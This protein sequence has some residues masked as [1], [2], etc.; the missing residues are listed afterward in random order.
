MSQIQE[1]NANLRKE[2][3]TLEYE[4][5]QL[6]H[7][8][9][10]LEEDI[11]HA[12]GALQEA[13]DEVNDLDKE[14]EQVKAELAAMTK[15]CGLLQKSSEALKTSSDE[16]LAA[17]RKRA[18]E[19]NNEKKILEEELERKGKLLRSQEDNIDEMEDTIETLR[20]A[21]QL[22]RGTN[23]QNEKNLMEA[24]E[25]NAKLAKE[26][27]ELKEKVLSVE[28][29]KLVFQRDSQRLE[30]AEEAKA[31]LLKEM[32]ELKEKLSRAEGERDRLT[33]EQSANGKKG[34]AGR[35]PRAPRTDG[36]SASNP[37]KVRSLDI[38]SSFLSF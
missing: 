15:F 17:L 38:P 6:S 7:Q 14:G 20:T 35:G 13:S 5:E 18:E 22:L 29:Q 34:R 9:Q 36:G 4:V 10:C 30:A 37:K 1:E 32:D 2:N 21:N 8:R 27:D 25:A 3:S 24:K 19:A 26:M 16:E 23:Q 33:K 11:E 31:D 12:V 28:K